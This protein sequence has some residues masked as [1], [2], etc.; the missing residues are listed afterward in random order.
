MPG[1]IGGEHDGTSTDYCVL[2]HEPEPQ[3]ECI[4]DSKLHLTRAFVISTVR[5][6]HTGF[7][8]P[9]LQTD[10]QRQPIHWAGAKETAM[11]TVM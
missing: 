11:S 2:T 5:L 4:G 6:Q 7:D 1:C 3:I 9:Q 10:A 8:L